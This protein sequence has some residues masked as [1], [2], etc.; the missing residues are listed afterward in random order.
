VNAVVQMSDRLLA[1]VW[2]FFA[3]FRLLLVYLC[4]FREKKP[5]PLRISQ[6]KGLCSST[7][8]GIYEPMDEV[9]NERP[10][11]RKVGESDTWLRYTQDAEW[12]ICKATHGDTTAPLAYASS[13]DPST[14]LPQDAQFWLSLPLCER[15][16]SLTD[17]VLPGTGYTC[18]GCDIIMEEGQRVFSCRDCEWDACQSCYHHQTRP[19]TLTIGELK[20]Q[21]LQFLNAPSLGMFCMFSIGA[22]H[23]QGWRCKGTGADE[24][25]YTWSLPL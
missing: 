3:L 23:C 6:A 16:H 25:N 24:N 18:K 12:I 13:M 2:H 14:A 7:V 22:V 17:F 19:L 11:F 5:T 20:A 4:V 10:L 8:N 9:L 1:V 15:G 21:V